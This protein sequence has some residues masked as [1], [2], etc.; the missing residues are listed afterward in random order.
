MPRFEIY[1]RTVCPYCTMAKRLLKSKDQK[2]VEINL[3]EE[4]S[5]TEGMLAR[6]GGRS[7]VPE[8]FL[9]G[10]FIGGWDDLSALQSS[11]ELDRMLA[12]SD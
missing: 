6:S 5:K 1:T 3:D 11:G 12:H 2:W 7:T 4:P 10:E 8:I 9:D